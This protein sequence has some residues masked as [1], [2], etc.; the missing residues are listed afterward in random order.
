[1]STESRFGEFGLIIKL[2]IGIAAGVV[3]GLM[4]N[5]AMMEV[6]VTA[7]YVMGQFIFILYRW[8]FWPLSPRP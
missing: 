1:M 5:E 6:V 2:V 8:L 4:A 7:K 3:I